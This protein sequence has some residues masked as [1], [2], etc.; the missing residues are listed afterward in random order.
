MFVNK[1]DFFS[2]LVL[3]DPTLLVRWFGGLQRRERRAGLPRHRGGPVRHREAVQ[4]R[5]DRRLRS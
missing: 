3:N 5:K 4:M 1:E 2:N